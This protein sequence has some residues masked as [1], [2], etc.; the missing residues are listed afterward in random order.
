VHV[1]VVTVELHIPLARSL[2]D[3]RAVVKPIVEG[4]RHRFGLSV[5]EVGFQD[6]WQR[7]A[8]GVAVVSGTTAHAV[9]VVG[10]VERWIWSRPD[11]EVSSI[12]TSW[13][14]PDA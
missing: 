14:D 2:K 5:A 8:I 1:A 6:R 10:S 3:K 7:A 11:V 12:G 13:W 9:E 4:I